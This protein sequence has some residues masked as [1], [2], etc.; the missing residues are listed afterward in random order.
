MRYRTSETTDNVGASEGHY[1]ME[2]LFNF[3]I[4]SIRFVLLGGQP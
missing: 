1:L 2:N 4:R 3:G